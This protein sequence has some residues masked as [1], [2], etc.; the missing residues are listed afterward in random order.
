MIDLAKLP[1]R[2]E[3]MIKLNPEF[4]RLPDDSPRGCP[5]T[6]AEIRRYLRAETGTGKHE[7]FFGR[8]ALVAD[9]RFWLWGYVENGETYYLYVSERNGYSPIDFAYGEEI[10]PEQF[11]ALKYASQWR[12]R[13]P[14]AGT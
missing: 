5:V 9:V 6:M 14:E 4:P 8:T 10:T 2:R 7:L 12:D 3:D 13:R 11:I 1:T